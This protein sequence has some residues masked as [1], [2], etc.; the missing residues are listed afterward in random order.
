MVLKTRTVFFVALLFSVTILSQKKWTLKECV[1]YALENNISIKQNKLN[2]NLAEKDVDIAKGNFLPNLTGSSNGTY[3]EGLSNSGNG[4][5]TNTKNFTSNFSVSSSGTIFN[6]FVNL[7]TYKQAQLGVESSKLDLEVIENDIAL[8]VV[9]T[10]LNVLFAEENLEVAKVQSEISKKQ[11]EQFKVR[12]EAGAIPKSD[13]LNAEATAA[14]DIQNVVTQ[15]NA[16][17]IALLNLSQLLQVPFEGFNIAEIEVGSPSG[18]MLYS[19]SE[20]VYKKALNNRPEIERAQ[21]NIDNLDISIDLAK[22]AYL[23]TLSYTIGASTSYFNQFN[24]L[25]FISNGIEFMTTNDNFFKQLNERF[26]YG[27]TLSLNVPIFNRFSN[28]K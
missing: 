3:N 1:N 16:L 17:N 18:A 28:K 9:N 22:G 2:I 24:N 19:T 4:T 12:F 25:S 7:N 5:L 26:N 14:N 13:V 20:E 27:A 11:I 8:N 21:L 15:E 6:G 10:Y 23:P